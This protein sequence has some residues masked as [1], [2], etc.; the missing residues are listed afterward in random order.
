MLEPLIKGSAGIEY[1]KSNF[2]KN[3]GSPYD[4]PSRLP[5]VCQWLSS[6]SRE[7]EQNWVEYQGSLSDI[8]STGADDSKYYS[9][10]TLRTG[11]SALRLPVLGASSSVTGLFDKRTYSHA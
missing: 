2:T 8:K 7:S 3:Y 6:V 9:P 10:A 4:A 1:L 5:I 11:G